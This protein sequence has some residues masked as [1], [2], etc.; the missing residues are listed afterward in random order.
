MYSKTSTSNST[1]NYKKKA[2]FIRARLERVRDDIIGYADRYIYVVQGGG[3][4]GWN[5]QTQLCYKN[6]TFIL[7]LFLD[8]DH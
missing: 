5:R 6:S 8:L 4:E 2:Q 7:T 1:H 3:G